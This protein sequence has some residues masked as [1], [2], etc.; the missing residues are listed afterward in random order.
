MNPTRTAPV[1]PS[2]VITTFACG[3][4]AR[5]PA[6]QLT[7]VQQEIRAGRACPPCQR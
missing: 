7:S 6:D 3:H 2:L 5:V 1:Q 4:G